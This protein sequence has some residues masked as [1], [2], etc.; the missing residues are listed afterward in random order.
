MHHRVDVSA[1]LLFGQLL[2]ALLLL[3]VEGQR[4]PAGFYP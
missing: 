1:L 2:R 3:I 4:M